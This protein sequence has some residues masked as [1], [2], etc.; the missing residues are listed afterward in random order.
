MKQKLR[1]DAGSVNMKRK[2][3]IITFEL[4]DESIEET[5]KRIAQELLNWFQEDAV[6][7][8]WVKNIKDITVKNA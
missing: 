2:T 4:V 3:V 6:S 8:P 5:D 1:I 7:I